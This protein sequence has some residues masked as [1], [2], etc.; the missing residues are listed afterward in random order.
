MLS[1]SPIKRK[2]YLVMIIAVDWDVK[3]KIK[4]VSS[5]FEQLFY[6]YFCGNIFFLRFGYSFGLCD[7]IR[8]YFRF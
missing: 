1:R 3:H 6:G 8:I 4:Q 5:K 7:K 2:Q